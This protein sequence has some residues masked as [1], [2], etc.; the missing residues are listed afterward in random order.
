[1]TNFP[2]QPRN[3]V[4]HSRRRRL[5]SASTT[6]LTNKIP[7][8]D[9][10]AP[11]KGNRKLIR[12][13]K[14]GYWKQI[15]RTVS[16]LGIVIAVGTLCCFIHPRK[17]NLKLLYLN[18]SL[19]ELT[20]ASNQ[21]ANRS[22]NEYVWDGSN[23]EGKDVSPAV[24]SWPKP[25]NAIFKTYSGQDKGK[26][27]RMKKYFERLQSNGKLLP[28]RLDEG[29]SCFQEV[30]PSVA[31]Y[32][33]KFLRPSSTTDTGGYRMLL[34]NALQEDRFW[35]GKRIF[36]GGGTLEMKEFPDQC[37]GEKN[38]ASLPYVYSKRPPTIP[39][40]G[41]F[42][43]DDKVEPVELF[44][45]VDGDNDDHDRS[46]TVDPPTKHFPCSVPC[47]LNDNYNVVNMINV[48]NTNWTITQTMEG[49]Q[50]YP[51][52][53][54]RPSAY[55]QSQFYA[56][57]SFK[58]EIPVPYYSRNEYNIQHAAVDFQ[59]A[60]KGA[61]FLA[62]NCDS[63]IKRERVVKVLIKTPL[64]VDSLSGC[65]NNVEPLPGVDMENKTAVMEQYL[66]HLAFEN[67]KTD[68]YI[69]EKLWGALA[70][71][72][73]PIYLGAGNIKEHVPSNSIIFA[74]DFKSPEDLADYLIR[75]A[76]DKDLYENYHKW[77]Y[78]SID[79]AFASKYEFTNTHSNCRMCKWVFAKRHGFGWN[80][81]KQTILKPLIDHKT[82]RNEMGLIGHPFKEYWLFLMS[83]SENGDDF[84]E[85]ELDVLSTDTT[86]SCSLNEDNR[87]IE[88]D[89][90]AIRRKVYD[91][92]GVTD[93]IIDVTAG[94]SQIN[95]KFDHYI[96][97]LTPPI[98][99]GG[100]NQLQHIVSDSALWLQDNDSRF[101]VMASGSSGINL[102]IHKTG[103]IEI[104][105]P[106]PSGS[107][108]NVATTRVR[109]VTENMD[110]FH[111]KTKKT[112]SYFGDLMMR[113]FF[114]PV[115]SYKIRN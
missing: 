99:V 87:L 48:R 104:H 113:D 94:G 49:E 9:T 69:T 77:R 115:A 111:Q 34:H 102:S 18:K 13:F 107:T 78:R 85:S 86:K 62:N 4:F 26:L 95:K 17:W 110:H 63:M 112:I 45:N 82:C 50:I 42:T 36:G 10:G 88:V 39:R 23:R 11:K 44:W 2:F 105:V 66:F 59:K 55:R 56:T 19:S 58:S 20:F 51:E 103:A 65:L 101:Y 100:G 54:V 29:D 47:K 80:H 84:E 35:C 106:P 46:R 12:R 114:E 14:Y 32:F 24:G 93:L 61:S 53:Q 57:T 30:T 71:G 40:E 1:M 33:S 79:E 5:A 22:N 64:R 92:D 43:G 15:W 108:T 38:Q 52:A 76:K 31:D 8:E 37:R 72:T 98:M 81:S 97:R 6:E 27:K 83:S 60:I 70:S 7:T 28:C 25:R 68:D 96:L 109:I 89:H 90:G 3:K 73:L 41:V 74:D 67:Q 75:L 91:H 21:T 16:T